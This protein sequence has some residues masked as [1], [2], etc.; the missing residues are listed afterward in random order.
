[1]KKLL[2]IVVLGLLLIT[3]S[4]ADDI[5][6]F[7]I[8]GISVGDSLLNFMN[9]EDI[10]TQLVKNDYLYNYTDKK[11]ISIKITGMKS[12][13]YDK[14]IIVEVKRK[15]DL[16]YI[17]YS[18][19]GEIIFPGMSKCL[20]QKN[21]IVSEIESMFTDIKKREWTRNYPGSTDDRYK[22]HGANLD[23]NSGDTIG[24]ICSQFPEN[25][26]PKRPD[27]FY[28]FIRTKVFEDWLAQY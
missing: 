1:M 7:Q 19:R 23:F 15:N 16:K 18:V 12:D 21:K 13:L 27:S 28:V 10:K 4:Q 3:P 26:T 5:R 20:A 8:E 14:R 22:I 9:I 17:I 25:L 11:F 6:D 2:G 24:V